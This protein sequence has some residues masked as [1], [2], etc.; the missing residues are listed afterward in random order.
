M[1]LW[2]AFAA[3][4]VFASVAQ[5]ETLTNAS[6]ITLSRAGLG[7]DVIIAKIKAT[8]NQFDLTTDQVIALK[9]TGISGAIL[10]AMIAASSSSPVSDKGAL[11][12]DSPDP[13]VPHPSGVYLLADSPA[14]GKMLRLDPTTANQTKTGGMLG[15]ALTGGLASVSM[16]SILPG[17]AARIATGGARPTFYFYFDQANQSLSGG[18]AGGL[19]L[20]GMS[21][22]TSP[23]EFSL[24]RFDVKKDRREA[25]VG[26]FNI[27]GAKTGVMDKDRIA[28]SYEQV[29]PG[30][31]KA[32]PS[33][34]LSEGQYGF[35]YSVSGGS[36]PGLYSRGVMT[37]K[38]FDFGIRAGV[39][40]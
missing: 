15:Y 37:S 34:D 19:W 14:P 11:S 29:A 17:A 10:A 21:S 9:Q 20:S 22:V 25:R 28:F 32:T 13:L 8:A 33:G 3:A 18:G 1:K 2:I 38:V 35:L 27:A 16:K 26:S 40:K 6:I 31:F 39:A 7:D 12:A 24:V 23:N 36:G 4:L 5:A 30:V